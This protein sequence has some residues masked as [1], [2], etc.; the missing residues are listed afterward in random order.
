MIKKCNE[1]KQQQEKMVKFFLVCGNSI[2]TRVAQRTKWNCNGCLPNVF[3]VWWGSGK[4]QWRETKQNQ[5]KI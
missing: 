4:L 1:H 2:V 3:S 5:T